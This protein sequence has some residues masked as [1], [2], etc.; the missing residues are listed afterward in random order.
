MGLGDGEASKAAR[1]LVDRDSEGLCQSETD[2][3]ASALVE[4]RVLQRQRVAQVLPDDTIAVVGRGDDP[5][6]DCAP[7]AVQRELVARVCIPYREGEQLGLAGERLVERQTIGSVPERVEPVVRD[8]GPVG[9]SSES[10]SRICERPILL[11]RVSVAKQP[12]AHG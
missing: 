10:K 3:L 1:A 2:L 5:S 6:S 7:F 12:S 9:A 11:F 8:V 4:P